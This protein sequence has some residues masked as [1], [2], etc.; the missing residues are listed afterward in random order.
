MH[1]KSQLLI[2]FSVKNP[3]VHGFALKYFA[4]FNSLAR[5]LDLA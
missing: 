4:W 3:K 2:F 1:Q 5:D